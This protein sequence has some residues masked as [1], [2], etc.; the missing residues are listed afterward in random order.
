MIILNH[1]SL[2]F[3]SKKSLFITQI[4]VVCEF[5]KNIIK[6]RIVQTLEILYENNN[7]DG[8]SNAQKK[9]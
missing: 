6:V 2:I 5:K 8:K 7:K 4:L 3:S 9:V 1:K